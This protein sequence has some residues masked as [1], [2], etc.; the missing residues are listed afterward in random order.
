[1][2]DNQR[3][4]ARRQAAQMAADKTSEAEELP[5]TESRNSEEVVE[6]AEKATETSENIVEADKASDKN[7]L[8]A[9]KALA[10]FECQICDFKSNWEN[11]VQIHMT[12]KHGTIEQLDG[13]SEEIDEKYHRTRHYW[14]RGWLGTS[15]QVFLDGTKIVEE[16]DLS[17]VD[18]KK[19]K[20]N[21]LEARKTAFGASFKFNPPWSL[22]T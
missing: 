5:L 6:V 3:R 22:K 8:K 19:E 20:E 18:K 16:S 15:Y 9:E 7:I 21:I 4:Q 13:N 2:V 11:G 10:I 17:E 12:R 14:E 1:M